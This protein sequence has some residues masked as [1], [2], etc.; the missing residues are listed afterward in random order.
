[1]SQPQETPLSAF[2]S[3]EKQTPEQTFLR[4]PA[5]D[6]WRTWTYQRAGDEVRRI[7]AALL[8]L[9]LPP[10]S[11]IVILSKNC[12]HWIMAD[13]AIMMAGHVSVP[14]YPTLPS[15]ALKDLLQHCECKAIFIGKLDNFDNLKEGIDPKIR[16][17]SF[18]I[19]GPDEGD[20]W[21]DLLS[22]HQPLTEKVTPKPDDVA[23]IMYS[24][25]TTGAP[26]G[27][28]IS[29]G[30]FGYVGSQ[31][32]Q[33]FRLKTPQKFF[34]YLPLSHIAER[35]LMEMVALSTGSSISFAQSVQ[36]FL[37]DLRHE[38]PTIFG[39]VPR[40]YSKF[41]EGILQR[42]SDRRLDQLLSVPGLNIL[43]RRALIKSLGLS[44]AANIVCGAAPIPVSLLE[45]FNKIGIEIREMYGMTENTAYSHAN[46]RLIRNGSVG[47]PWPGVDVKIEA[48]GEILV[49]HPALMKGYYKDPE[50]T[51]LAFAEEGFLR[52]GD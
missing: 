5:S 31:V 17:I 23:S 21:D 45:W 6:T 16:R 42:I 14:I 18:P 33:Y 28:M 29:F 7:A 36:T 13:L 10:K 52:T 47:Q 22:R 50:A 41:R 40:I 39:G 11:N 43:I 44:R 49:R 1:M 46:F 34:S 4:Q 38:Q 48:D 3:W 15:S 12:A 9:D 26:K 51:K 35:A 8:A 19:Y 24:S 27:A 25:G 32:K 2:Y 30:A 20:R 37:Q